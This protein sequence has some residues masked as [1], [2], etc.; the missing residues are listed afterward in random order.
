MGLYT[1]LMKKKR[2]LPH[3]DYWVEDSMLYDV[4]YIV[5]PYLYTV[6]EGKSVTD[7]ISSIDGDLK[8]LAKKVNRYFKTRNDVIR[9]EDE[10]LRI[11]HGKDV[12]KNSVI[13][14]TKLLSS[15]PRPI[16]CYSNISSTLNPL[17]NSKTPVC[18]RVYK[19]PQQKLPTSLGTFTYSICSLVTTLPQNCLTQTV[20]TCSL[21]RT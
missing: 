18:P 16:Y 8:E 15:C 9:T 21:G 19:Y 2:D 20:Q 4:K 7:F 1:R 11:I 10:L 14:T 13:A 3:V 17:F 6:Y 12:L 5:A